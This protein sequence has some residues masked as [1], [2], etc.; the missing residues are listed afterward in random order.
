[1]L[2]SGMRL[3][4]RGSQSGPLLG[5]RFHIRFT[6]EHGTRP[7]RVVRQSTGIAAV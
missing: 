6:V 1:M 5:E 3:W 4:C 7:K 2:C